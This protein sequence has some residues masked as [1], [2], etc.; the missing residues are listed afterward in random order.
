MEKHVAFEFPSKGDTRSKVTT[1]GS[2][3][4]RPSLLEKL[5]LHVD[6]KTKRMK[7]KKK[8]R[9]QTRK[10]LKAEKEER[11]RTRERGK[12]MTKETLIKMMEAYIAEKKKKKKKKS[13]KVPVK[14]SKIS[15]G[16]KKRKA[17]KQK[18][19]SLEMKIKGVK[20]Q[21][22]LFP[23]TYRIMKEIG[24]IYQME[25]GDDKAQNIKAAYEARE[26][27]RRKEFEKQRAHLMEEVGREYEVSQRK[28][29]DISMEWK[30]IAKNVDPFRISKDF[31]IQK[32]RGVELLESKKRLIEKL[33]AKFYEE[34]DTS[35]DEDII[36]QF[37]TEI[38]TQNLGL[39]KAYFE[40]LE[41]NRYAM[42]TDL[43]QLVEDNR[44]AYERARC[45]REALTKKVLRKLDGASLKN[46]DFQNKSIPYFNERVDRYETIAL[47]MEAMEFDMEYL[48]NTTEDEMV[49]VF[50]RCTETE[51]VIANYR[52]EIP[53][54]RKENM[55]TKVFTLYDLQQ[56]AIKSKANVAQQISELK[57]DVE[58]IR[59]KMV[60]LRDKKRHLKEQRKTAEKNYNDLW[61]HYDSQIDKDLQKI[62]NMDRYIQEKILGRHWETPPSTPSEITASESTIL[63]KA[64]PKEPCKQLYSLSPE[65]KQRR[66]IDCVNKALLAHGDFVL[67]KLQ[68][69]TPLPPNLETFV[70]LNR[71]LCALCVNT[72][73]DLNHLVSCLA[74]Y[75]YC[76]DCA[77]EEE[78]P[79]AK[80]NTIV[81]TILDTTCVCPNDKHKLTIEGSDLFRGIDEYMKEE[82]EQEP[83]KPHHV[84]HVQD[85]E[86]NWK[87]K[88]SI[89]TEEKVVLF[90]AVR[91]ILKN[92]YDDLVRTQLE[93]QKR[94]HCNNLRNKY[95]DTNLRK[96][97][98]KETKVECFE[99]KPTSYDGFGDCKC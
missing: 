42:F 68:L 23:L 85:I 40:Y 36:K 58:Y 33:L 1:P 46:T 90:K 76:I 20:P 14:K 4:R 78:N 72:M 81:K 53:K 88:A 97:F 16:K 34:I 50:N 59:N 89:I 2:R 91:D 45:K 69:T 84:V 41:S 65:A 22:E 6:K 67:Q 27:K 95:E 66:L 43:K 56:E 29:F 18:G 63:E 11:R 48:K 70:K 75:M 5:K 26:I 79:F 10:K 49:S 25:W 80:Y 28:L 83:E 21:K 57:Q 71:I 73:E 24:N 44:A 8:L 99:N 86:K 61:K 37:H 30:R 3:P 60:R 7:W 74:P 32:Q 96:K 55:Q 35:Y 87:C 13:L 77:R 92:H 94:Q 15:I 51:N 17:K 52:A 54:I 19:K 62:T 31:E 47:D 38:R 82:P 98:R 64:P 12:P 9:R 93:K 39:G